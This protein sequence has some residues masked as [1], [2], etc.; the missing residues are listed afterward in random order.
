MGCTPGSLTNSGTCDMDLDAR[1]AWTHI[2]T[3][4]SVGCSYH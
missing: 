2:S 3:A 4:V 1:L